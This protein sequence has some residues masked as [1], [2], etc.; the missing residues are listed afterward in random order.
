MEEARNSLEG[1]INLSR[2]L[3]MKGILED[4]VENDS[5][6]NQSGVEQYT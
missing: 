4:Y 2:N 1:D 6:R 3:G 5:S